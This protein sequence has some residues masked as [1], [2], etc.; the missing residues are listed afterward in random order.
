MRIPLSQIQTDDQARAALRSSAPPA[1]SL[2]E[3]DEVIATFDR[4]RAEQLDLSIPDA[5]VE[6]ISQ[7][8]ERKYA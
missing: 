4:V 3:V 2:A 1:Y 6:A 8:A 7:Q 5:M